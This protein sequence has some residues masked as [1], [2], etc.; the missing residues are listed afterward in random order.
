VDD[1]LTGISFHV[2]AAALKTSSH[3]N[4]PHTFKEVMQKAAERAKW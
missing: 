3:D 2:H 4:E 1:Y